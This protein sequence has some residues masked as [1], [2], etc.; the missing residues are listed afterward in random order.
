[1]DNSGSGWTSIADVLNEQELP[2]TRRRLPQ[3]LI[4][5]VRKCGTR[6]LL[7]FLNIHPSVVKA[8]DEV[9]FFDEDSKYSLGLKWYRDQMPPSRLDQVTIEKSPAYFVTE[10]APSRVLSMNSSIKIIVI[11][12]DPVVRLI[13]DYAQLA[14]NKRARRI[15]GENLRP[16]K[17]FEASVLL[18]DGQVDVNYKPV[19]TSI[20]G[21]HFSRWIQVR[22]FIP[23]TSSFPRISIIKTKKKGKMQ[24]NI[25]VC[26]IIFGWNISSSFK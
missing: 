20:Y 26:V 24:S 1:M 7:E 6:A 21:L 8:R 9:H 10:S 16:L 4:I 22:Q 19:Q 15:V 17:T 2:G 11:V 25:F 14:A 3:C 13:S 18:P 12:R 5:G 23:V